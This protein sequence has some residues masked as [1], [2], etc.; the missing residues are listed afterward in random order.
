MALTPVSATAPA[1]AVT[2]T[3]GTSKT[4]ELTVT[5]SANKAVDLTGARII[6]TMKR[7]SEDQLP[8]TQKASDDPLQVELSAPREGKAKIYLLPA[9]TQN[10]DPKSY[11]FDVWVIL[12]NGKRYVVVEPTP[13]TLKAGVTLIPL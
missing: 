1:N 4:L 9:D 12:S 2:V 7:D 3:R 8:L 5:D 10:L 13:I 6:F 11:I